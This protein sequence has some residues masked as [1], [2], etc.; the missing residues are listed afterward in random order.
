MEFSRATDMNKQLKSLGRYVYNSSMKKCTKC[1]LERDASEFYKDSKTKDMLSFWCK[2]CSKEKQR[3]YIS[4]NREREKQRA[5]I[6]AQNN[7]EKISLYMK[8]YRKKNLEK[9]RNY[10][11]ARI[12]A[13][14]ENVVNHY[15]GKCA[16]CGE[17]I[18]EFLSLDHINGDGARERR[19]L[20]GSRSAGG[21]SIYRLIIKNNYPK[22][23]Y[24]ILCMN[25]NFA[26]GHNNNV[27]PH[28]KK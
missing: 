8:G 14:K 20:F 22:N 28:K 2:T 17:T 19:E 25:C 3:V 11:K 10:D 18:L 4:K 6:Y 12:R 15:G 27:C 24:Q 9:L 13:L 23:R 21:W 16:C 1:K 7:K 26:K 5:S